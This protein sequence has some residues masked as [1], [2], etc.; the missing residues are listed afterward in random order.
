MSLEEFV[1][2]EVL[3]EEGSEEWLEEGVVRVVREERVDG[4][5]WGE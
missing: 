4:G 5:V 3:V 1:N 2:G